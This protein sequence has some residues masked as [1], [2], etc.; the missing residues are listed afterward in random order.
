MIVQVYRNTNDPFFS[1]FFEITIP[2]T[3]SV[4]S[5]VY[6]FTYSDADIDVSNA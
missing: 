3:Q 4:N 1:G 2:E 6:Q 5:P